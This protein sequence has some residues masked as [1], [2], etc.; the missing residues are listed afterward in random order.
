M[1]LSITAIT[2]IVLLA[3]KELASAS[4]SAPA[5]RLAHLLTLPIIPLLILF[6]VLVALRMAEISV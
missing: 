2:L 4:D 3:T 1:I 6:V 5:W